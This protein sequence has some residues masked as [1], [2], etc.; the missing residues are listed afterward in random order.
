[1]GTR[2]GTGHGSPATEDAE[3]SAREDH[4]GGS[5]KRTGIL[6]CRPAN[7][8][9]RSLKK[10]VHLYAYFLPG[11]SDPRCFYRGYVGAVDRAAADEDD[12]GRRSLRLR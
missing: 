11:D 8:Y 10:T 6:Y 7:G 5:W 3:Q 2:N 9:F 12:G 4:P 1:M